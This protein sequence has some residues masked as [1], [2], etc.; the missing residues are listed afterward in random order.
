MSSTTPTSQGVAVPSIRP[1]VA[2]TSW[3]IGFTPTNAS[4]Q[5]GS[6][7]GSTKVLLRNVSGKSAMKPVFMTAFGAR[8]ISPSV[9]KTHA[10]PKANTTTS[11]TP[12]SSPARPA[13][14][15]KPMISPSAT[16]TDAATTYRR[17][18]PSIAPT[19]GAGRQIGS[20]R[21]RSTTP[22][23]TSVFRVTPE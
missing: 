7:R 4:S 20:E 5:P 2:V 22:F 6:V 15:R 19:S 13:P 3:E 21:K 8:R 12:A 23:V 14:G 18:S 17:A 16:T 1:R 9:V 10:R 11:R